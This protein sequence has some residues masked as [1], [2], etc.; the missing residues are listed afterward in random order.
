[1]GGDIPVDIEVHVVSSSISRSIG[2]GSSTHTR[3]GAHK[4]ISI[5]VCI[6]FRK[7]TCFVARDFLL[8]LLMNVGP[9]L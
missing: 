5:Y 7:K 4:R 1:V 8:L 3:Q 6:V 2:S 9:D